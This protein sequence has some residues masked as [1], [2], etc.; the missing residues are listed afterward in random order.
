MCKSIRSAGIFLFLAMAQVC[1]SAERHVPGEYTTLQSAISASSNG[2]EIILDPNTYSGEGFVDISFNGLAITVRS[3]DPN[4]PNIV[5]A[6]II[7][8]N[9]PV[10]AFVFDHNEG[11]NSI[12]NGLTIQNGY[13][14]GVYCRQSSP[15]IKNCRFLNY[16][17]SCRPIIYSE[18][19]KI[20]IDNCLFQYGNAASFYDC[21]EINI[22]NC[23]FVNNLEAVLCRLSGQ[24]NIT[25]SDFSYQGNR[26]IYS[27]ETD[28]LIA[29]CNI[30]YNMGN[31]NYDSGTV[32]IDSADYCR[33][34]GSTIKQNKN[35]S[36]IRI[37]NSNNKAATVTDINNC[38]ITNNTSDNTGAGIWFT[39]TRLNIT[40]SRINGN[41]GANT[42]S[43]LR[44]GGIYCYSYGVAGGGLTVSNSEICYNSVDCFDSFGAGI[45]ASGNF[46]I[47]NCLIK[48][49][50]LTGSIGKGAAISIENGDY[51]NES[52][53]ENCTIVSN[54]GC[55]GGA[56]YGNSARVD[57]VNCIIAENL[58]DEIG[59]GACFN[60][61]TVDFV[62]CTI[63]N[64]FSPQGR[65]L[66]ISSSILHLTN[67]IFAIKDSYD[68]Y[69]SP[70]CT[71][72]VNH[73]LMFGDPK[74][75]VDYRL[76]ADSPCIDAGDPHF[77]DYPNNSDIDGEDRIHNIVDIGA[78]EFIDNDNDALPNFWEERYFSDANIADANIDS[79]GDG[80]INLDEYHNYATEPNIPPTTYYVSPLIGND[81]YDG[82]SAIYDDNDSGPKE[83]I[84]A[85]IALC[86][87]NHNDKIIL[88]PAPYTEN[89]VDPLGKA[90]TISGTNPNDPNIVRNTFFVT[91]NAFNF[92]NFEKW[93][94]IIDG[95][96]IAKLTNFDGK[97]AI[98]A[99]MSSPT[100]KNC[101]IA[102]CGTDKYLWCLGGRPKF[103]NNKFKRNTGYIYFDKTMPV[104]QNC[105]FDQT[106]TTAM[107]AQYSTL[108]IESSYFLRNLISLQTTGSKVSLK[109][110][111]IKANNF[112]EY[113]TLYFDQ[114]SD[115]NIIN[116]TI[117]GNSPAGI[118]NYPVIYCN[119]SKLNMTN[120]ILRTP[121][122]AKII[123]S[124]NSQIN[125]NYCNIQD[126][127]PSGEGNFDA[128]PNLT[129]DGHLLAGSFCINAGTD[130][131][132]SA[133]DIDGEIRPA[134]GLPDIGADEYVDSD[135]D[136]LPNFFAA[137]C[138][139]AEPNNDDDSDGYTNKDEY[140]IYSSDPN[141][142]YKTFYVASNGNKNNSG[143]SWTYPKRYIYEAVDFANNGDK[144]II[145]AMS[146]N[147]KPVYLN[148]KAVV[149]QSSNPDSPT[150][151]NTTIIPYGAI[152]RYGEGRGSKICGINITKSQAGSENIL[153]AVYCI[154]TQPTIEKCV[155]KSSTS[156]DN[157]A[158]VYCVAASPAITDCN[159]SGNTG[160]Y[161]TAL[162]GLNKSRPNLLRCKISKNTASTSGGA[163][164]LTEG[165]NATIEQCELKSNTAS[166]S[167]GAV[168]CQD[169]SLAVVNSILSNNN[170]NGTD[171]S[172]G[173]YCTGVELNIS[174][175]G[176]TFTQ[177]TGSGIYIN[178]FSMSPNF[179]IENSVFNYNSV[180]PA[181]VIISSQY[182]PIDINKCSFYGNVAGALNLNLPYAEQIGLKNCL[183]TGNY[184]IQDSAF[185]IYSNVNPVQI[186]IENCTI[187]YN[188]AGDTANC[189]SI[190]T[191]QSSSSS[192]I[193]NRFT[194]SIIYGNS[195]VKSDC[196]VPPYT[197]S[198]SKWDISYCDW[199]NLNNLKQLP[200]YRNFQ[201]TGCIDSEPMFIDPGAWGTLPATD[202]VWTQGDYHLQSNG[203]VWFDG[204]L[205]GWTSHTSRCVD[206][207]SPGSPL[208]DEPIY[209]VRDPLGLYG[210]NK[211]I[212][213]GFYGGTEQASIPP[214][215]WMLL[216]DINN[217]G[218]VDVYDLYFL[219]DSYLSEDTQEVS[220]DIR[221]DGTV[222]LADYTLLAAEWLDTASWR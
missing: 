188:K 65:G 137:M 212:N 162:Y 175:T 22:N 24:L 138:R 219:I 57:F 100:I 136:G 142:P 3:T 127:W 74:L 58:A 197:I 126:G 55:M 67:T 95:L 166:T 97:S 153:N 168:Y 132:C 62:N 161:G 215:N 113:G 146:H 79:D 70:G 85:A 150:I 129:P 94:T 53:V 151:V 110:S 111:V 88:L 118:F 45:A 139:T 157:G 25:N 195:Q 92:T 109:N 37:A 107:Q 26:T 75:T 164:Y 209:G 133:N 91:P 108:D 169:S 202:K 41:A 120:T 90:I 210:I 19:D 64:N 193:R 155:I 186:D 12:L 93:S 218:T 49:N 59:G 200:P 83:T 11:A 8:C 5:A 211:R 116:C 124:N 16:S 221:H 27:F 154:A 77:P 15:T 23:V 148:G 17:S 204:S 86:R 171:K 131:N 18:A 20:T 101:V 51:Q 61:S 205:K 38:D 196:G 180:K 165:S 176:C 87:N 122:D 54:K 73:C 63:V 179:V 2:D 119:S 140:E 30:A 183:F 213:M 123:N 98:Y 1:F 181:L 69:A 103:I 76:Q 178:S 185:Y 147:D 47:S 106:S 172:A 78:D 84:S 203:W 158:G 135:S 72:Y 21:N 121:Y 128:E 114:S 194:N 173:I 190:F 31:V 182:S 177:N 159:I 145:S 149:L 222:N 50:K 43:Q 10:R 104:I 40:N 71:E 81:A 152:F 105:Q 214:N 217:D 189:K 48:G 141:K 39:G 29:D 187:A 44:G 191:V 96:S 28:V 102:E 206:A 220:A 14:D 52:I 125:V 167:G 192:S 66:H 156:V 160:Y 56:I 170:A 112:G 33:I 143:L 208:G 117:F 36:G 42:I 6:T 89:M 99:E 199:Q 80:I 32:Y 35:Q 13:L 60:G 198:S 144:I 134:D 68:F 9:A 201:W 207:G 82:L 7:S 4:D 130:V 174:V 34:E 163:V 216:A 46:K 184:N 115:A